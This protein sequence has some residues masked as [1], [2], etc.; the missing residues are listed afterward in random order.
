V[1]APLVGVIGSLQAT[2]SLKLLSGMGAS[3]S[4]QLMLF[5]A[6]FMEWQTIQTRR[7]ADCPVCSTLRT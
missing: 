1:L 7:Q 3:L 2:E 4:G 6:Q 5:N